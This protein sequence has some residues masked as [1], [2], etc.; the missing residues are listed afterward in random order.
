TWIGSAMFGAGVAFAEAEQ[1][2]LRMW[3]SLP[4]TYFAALVDRPTSGALELEVVS[5]EGSSTLSV[6]VP[7]GLSLVY[8]RSL[9][10]GLTVAHATAIRPGRESG[11]PT[12]DMGTTSSEPARVDEAVSANAAGVEPSGD[13][14]A[15]YAPVLVARMT[16]AGEPITEDEARVIVRQRLSDGPIEAPSVAAGTRD[17]GPLVPSGDQVI[18]FAAPVDR[19]AFVKLVA[20]DGSGRSTPLFLPMS[21]RANLRLVPGEYSV[22]VATGDDWYGWDLDF[23]PDAEYF[24][25]APTVVVESETVGPMTISLGHPEFPSDYHTRQSPSRDARIEVIARDEFIQQ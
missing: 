6:E 16:A 11:R 22:L 2:D 25:L 10:P 18:T 15:V 1:P 19:H 20:L 5:D 14:A 4:S 13:L 21:R 17:L 12:L 9:E 3:T 24:E 23:G 8:V 7:T